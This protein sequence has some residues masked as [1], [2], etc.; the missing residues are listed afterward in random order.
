[1]TEESLFLSIKQNV[2]LMDSAPCDA[3]SVLASKSV[4][5]VHW[6]TMSGFLKWEDE[7]IDGKQSSKSKIEATLDILVNWTIKDPV[8]GES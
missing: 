1:M 3:E 7:T 5:F 6:R 4:M 8:N 2:I